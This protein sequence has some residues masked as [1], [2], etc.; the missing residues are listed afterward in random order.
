MHPHFSQEMLYA[1]LIESS[2]RADFPLL[3]SNMPG[4]SD[5][6]R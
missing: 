1:G 4:G 2:V 3:G 6:I 5:D